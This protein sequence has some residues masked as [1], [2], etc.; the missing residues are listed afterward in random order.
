MNKETIYLQIA[1]GLEQLGRG[2]NSKEEREGEFVDKY[3]V[4]KLEKCLYA[5]F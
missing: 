5:K 1:K 2:T 3:G 4:D